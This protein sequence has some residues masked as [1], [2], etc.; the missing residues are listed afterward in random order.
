MSLFPG[1]AG[2]SI[3][4]VNGQGL[5]EGHPTVIAVVGTPVVID[6]VVANDND[7]MAQSAH[8]SI[9]PPGTKLG[10]ASPINLKAADLA[11]PAAPQ[12]SIQSALR[13]TPPAPGLYP[14]FVFA[15]QSVSA[16]CAQRMTA[17]GARQTG[18]VENTIIG[19]VDAK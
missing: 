6:V 16:P 13:F 18:D 12:A 17:D 2:A 4:I 14:V 3:D 9:R 1:C 8:V 7:G 15:M 5:H 19:W 10:A 11:L